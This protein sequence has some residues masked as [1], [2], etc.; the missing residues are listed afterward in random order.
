[1]ADDIEDLRARVTAAKN[2]LSDDV[3]FARKV[4]LRLEDLVRI[5]RKLTEEPV[6]VP[7]E[8]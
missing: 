5:Y 4:E 2:R 1:M 6:A 8:Q 3:S 7:E